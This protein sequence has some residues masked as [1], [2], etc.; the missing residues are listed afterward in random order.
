MLIFVSIIGAGSAF[1][2]DSFQISPS[3]PPPEGT[4][5]TSSFVVQEPVDQST[6]NDLVLSTILEN[7]Q[8]SYIINVNEGSSGPT[9]SRAKTVSINSFLLTYKSDDQVNVSVTLTGTAPASSKNYQ[10]LLKIYELDDN[11]DMIPSSLYQYTGN[12]V[13][14]SRTIPSS[15]TPGSTLTIT[16]SPAQELNSVPGWVASESLPYGFDLVST[17]A[18]YEEQTGSNLYS[19][20]QT[21]STPISYVLRAPLT[22]GPYS[23]NGIF[24][25][26]NRNTGTICGD[27]MINVGTTYQK[28]RNATTGKIEKDDA[29]NALTDYLNGRLTNAG[30]GSVLQNYFLGQ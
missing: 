28:Y 1:T 29:Q 24:I 23:I 20:I 5:V 6:T 14:L 22:E 8:W 19:F 9:E 12:L 10:P 26:G 3:G 18:F 7:P 11:G 16:L 17:N 2:V 25:D 27:S 4:T 15:V 30:A 21:N 13:T